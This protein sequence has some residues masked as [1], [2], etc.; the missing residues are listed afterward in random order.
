MPGRSQLISVRRS[1]LLLSLCTALVG[2]DAAVTTS[3]GEPG[4]P[5]PATSPVRTGPA[6]SQQA[7]ATPSATAPVAACPTT[8][9]TDA[10]LAPGSARNDGRGIAQVW[11]PAGAFRMGTTTAEAAAVLRASLPAWVANELPGEQPA[12][13]VAISC[14][15]WLDR[16]EVTNAAFEAFVAAGGY[17]TRAY[18]SDEGWAGLMTH[19]SSVPADCENAASRAPRACITWYEAEAYATWRGGR[20]PTEAEWEYA[21][22]GPDSRIYPWGDAWDPS[23]A[24]VVSATAAADVGSYPDGDSWVGARDMAG[25]VMEWVADWRSDTYYADSPSIDPTGPEVGAIKV[26]KGG[27]WGSNPWVAR[28]AYRHFED[29]PFYED[30]HIGVRIVTPAELAA[31]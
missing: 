5:S 20:L 11:V 12:H 9:G 16:D 30:H 7:S 23:R 13:P 15:Y 24:N 31:S 21:A 17:T 22:R 19:A 27:W 1:L 26:E 28:S 2:C 10:E 14:G 4:S 18:W 6:E 3:Q 8:P 29:P 25:N